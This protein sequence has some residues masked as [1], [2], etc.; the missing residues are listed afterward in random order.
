MQTVIVN[1]D[2]DGEVKVEAQGVAGSGCQALTRAI[3]QALGTTS[4]D[5]KK[6]EFFQQ[7]S[8]AL[9]AR[10]QAGQK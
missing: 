1:I 7:Q 8:A 2:A 10:N 5:V 4:A 3:E 6:P 9:G